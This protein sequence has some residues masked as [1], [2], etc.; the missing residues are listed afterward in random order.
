MAIVLEKGRE[1]CFLVVVI[2]IIIVIAIVVVVVVVVVVAVV[3]FWQGNLIT[4]YIFQWKTRKI[5]TLF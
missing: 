3:G 1:F 4:H 2:H 5:A